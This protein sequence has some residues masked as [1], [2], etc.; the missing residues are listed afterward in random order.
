MTGSSLLQRYLGH[1]DATNELDA[2]LAR[3]FTDC[4]NSIPRKHFVVFHLVYIFHCKGKL[5]K[6]V[7]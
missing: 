3:Y 2:K 5:V 4:T 6:S 7:H 1:P